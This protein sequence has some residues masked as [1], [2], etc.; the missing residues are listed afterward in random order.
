M[1]LI[2]LDTANFRDLAALIEQELGIH[3]PDSKRSMLQSRLQRRFRQLGIETFDE[4]RELLLDPA[5]S[6]SERKQF[7]DLATTNKTDFFREP[8]HFDLLSGQILPDLDASL[9]KGEPIRIW[10]AGCSAGHE[11]YTIAM[12]A[13]RHLAGSGRPFVVLG[14][15]VCSS[16]LQTAREAVYPAAQAR[17]IPADYRGYLMQG[18]AARS[19]LFRIVPELRAKT[20][21][22]QLNFKQT[23]YPLERRVHVIFFRNVMIYFEPPMQEA[24][25]NRLCDLLEPGGY[26]LSGHAE[27]LSPFA[28]PLKQFAPAA[29]RLP[30]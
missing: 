20:R 13:D 16:V 3:M 1:S 19:G 26:F 21:F 27:S 23:R 9:P 25:L 29:Y 24:T 5:R 12:I 18:K 11:P 4:Y 10:S 15:D 30:V 2:C 14:T 7:F 17:A 6:Q 8:D 22:H 28:L